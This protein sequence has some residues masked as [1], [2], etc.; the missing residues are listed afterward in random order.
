MYKYK[1]IL[2]SLDF[3]R[4]SNDIFY[5]GCLIAN[6]EKATLHII[7]IIERFY[8]SS[9]ED[10]KFIYE[11][12]YNN[13]KEEMNKFIFE[14]P[15]PEVIIKEVIKHG[16]PDEEVLTYSIKNN[17]DLIIINNYGWEVKEYPL[18]IS[19]LKR[20]LN[21]SGIPAL[22]FSE[23]NTLNAQKFERLAENWVG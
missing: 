23:N 5:L 12:R 18:M 15:H 7:H 17:I 3:S 10:D 16:N 20:S 22:Y 14:I 13:A 6:H 8:Q 2:L 19:K 9:S 4:F 1:N 11:M 21:F